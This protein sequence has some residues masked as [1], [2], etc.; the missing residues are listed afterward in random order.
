M[1]VKVCMGYIIV[2]DLREENIVSSDRIYF[3]SDFS[4]HMGG[5][6]SR[7]FPH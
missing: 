4:T 7:L 3:D 2:S 5:G 1:E 6:G